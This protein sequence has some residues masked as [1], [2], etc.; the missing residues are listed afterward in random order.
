MDTKPEL[1]MKNLKI[2]VSQ[3][4]SYILYLFCSAMLLFIACEKDQHVKPVAGP[5]EVSH[6]IPALVPTAGGTYTLT[7]D[8]STNGWWMEIPVEASWLPVGRK[9]GAAKVVQ[10]L[11]I[12]ANGSAV[13]RSAT[14][15]IN[16]SNGD[17]ETIEVKQK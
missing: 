8:A 17:T 9:F 3:K 4:S 5:F 2:R 13:A 16:S 1:V 7:I 11:V 6:D 14:L 12:P 15:K 10:Q